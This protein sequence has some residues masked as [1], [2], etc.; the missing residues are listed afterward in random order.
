ALRTCAERSIALTPDKLPFRLPIAV[1][2][3]PTMTASRRSLMVFLSVHPEETVT[4]LN[5]RGRAS[6][7]HHVV[8]RPG[9]T[10][11]DLGLSVARWHQLKDHA[12]A[13]G[14][15]LRLSATPDTITTG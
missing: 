6:C 12:A 2:T 3:A 15:A 5:A 11:D 8:P 10:L 9:P 1:R 7:P 14:L 13:A 4:A